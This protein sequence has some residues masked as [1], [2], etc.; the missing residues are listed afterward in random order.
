MYEK[1]RLTFTTASGRAFCDV[2]D[3]AG[4]LV[5]RLPAYWLDRAT[6][7][8]DQ[9]NVRIQAVA[10]ESKRGVNAVAGRGGRR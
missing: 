1:W 3:A 4:A 7:L 10:Q 8:V 2:T 9:H 6:A 5:Y